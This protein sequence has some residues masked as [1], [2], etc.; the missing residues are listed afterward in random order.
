MARYQLSETELNAELDK[1]PDW[2]IKGGKLHKR[3]QF[4]SFSKAIGW[5]MSVAIHAEKMNHHPE[6]CNVYNQVEVNL[7]TH[8]LGEVI[9]NWDVALAQKMESLAL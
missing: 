4:D 2:I 3:F 5:M 8:D 6:W 1:L 7:I 9:S